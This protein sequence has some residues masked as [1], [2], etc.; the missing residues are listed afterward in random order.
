MKTEEKCRLVK[1]CIRIRRPGKA[2]ARHCATFS[3]YKRLRFVARDSSIDKVKQ[4]MMKHSILHPYPSCFSLII[5][6]LSTILPTAKSQSLNPMNAAEEWKRSKSTNKTD[7]ETRKILKYADRQSLD[8]LFW[9]SNLLHLW[10]HQ[11]GVG[12]P[13]APSTSAPSTI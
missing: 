7:S 13:E 3:E 9:V 8:L 11:K 12:R 2:V 4:G 5:H 10:P 6:V 1:N